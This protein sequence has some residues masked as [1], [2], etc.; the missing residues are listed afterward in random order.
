[1]TVKKEE[2]VSN[3]FLTCFYNDNFGNTSFI[4]AQITKI[5]A[6]LFYVSVNLEH[7]LE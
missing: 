1:M 2:Y 4:L 3:E 5:Y 7:F 6:F